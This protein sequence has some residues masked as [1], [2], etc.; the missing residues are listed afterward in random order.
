MFRFKQ[1]E[2]SH[3]R[4]AMRLGI[5]AVILGS[6][7]NLKDCCKIIDVG[8]G[9]GVIALMCAQRNQYA[10]I[11]AIDIDRES[12]EESIFNFQTSP[13]SD[14]L[15]RRHE[16]FNTTC[17]KK[18]KFDLII[19]NPPYFNSGIIHPETAR[20]K[21]RHQSD[22]SPFTLM[23][24]GTKIL[25]RNG[26]IAMIFPIAMLDDICRR[27]KKLGLSVLRVLKIKGRRDLP[28]KRAAIELGLNDYYNDTPYTQETLIIDE[29]PGEASPEFKKL[30]RDFYLKF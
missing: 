15:I 20:E 7:T 28:F 5:D 21:A 17:T 3:S 1:F 13:W 18:E 2:V 26:R 4:S 12:V 24:N 22:L 16:D 8:T 9:C 11:S 19:S 30:C 10:Q 14:R 25:N 23:E 6:W 27:G 29:R